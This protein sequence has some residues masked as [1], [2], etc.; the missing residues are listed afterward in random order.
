MEVGGIE[1]EKGTKYSIGEVAKFS[2]V[3]VR[4]L[5]YYDNIGLVP[6]EKDE[7]GRRFYSRN[8]L[9]R[10]QQALFFRSLGLSLKQIR[11][12]VV[13]AA[14]SDQIAE[15]LTNQREIYTEKLN[16]TH[17]Y[18]SA[19][20]AVLASLRTGGEIHS[21]ELVQLLT[22][23]NRG[24]VAEY[25]NVEYGTLTR[26][27]RKLCDHVGLVVFTQVIWAGQARHWLSVP[28][29]IPQIP[30]AT[31][32][33]DLPPCL[34]LIFPLPAVDPHGHISRSEHRFV[35]TDG[36]LDRLRIELFGKARGAVSIS[37]MVVAAHSDDVFACGG[38]LNGDGAHIHCAA[39][40]VDGALRR[41]HPDTIGDFLDNVALRGIDGVGSL[42]AEPIP[43]GELHPAHSFAP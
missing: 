13:E 28:A 32:R 40:A 37:C 35:L 39:A 20:D 29:D 22:R 23:L 42:T 36:N 1:V 33:E 14:T 31:A 16:E 9:V 8:D 11:E 27:E 34:K 19:I 26:M 10:L 15:I 18:I 3:T 24:A 2:G 41:D 43:F 38:E 30:E 25:R 21:E 6:I 4:T 12:L 17:G 5:Q 7:S